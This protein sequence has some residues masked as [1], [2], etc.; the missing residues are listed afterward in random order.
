MNISDGNGSI[1]IS[2]FVRC[3]RRILLNIKCEPALL[4]VVAIYG[5]FATLTFR[6]L[7]V[8]PTYDG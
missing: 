3:C 6:P 4:V 1:F 2:S 8:P 7:D 5:R